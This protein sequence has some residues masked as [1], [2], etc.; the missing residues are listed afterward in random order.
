ML[1]LLRWPLSMMSATKNARVPLS[2]LQVSTL[3][4]AHTHTQR[5][6]VFAFAFASIRLAGE[7]AT[8][9]Q[10]RLLLLLLG[11]IESVAN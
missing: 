11:M 10:T 5:A 4:H 2:L 9:F 3:T 8:P 1:S 7:R 6:K